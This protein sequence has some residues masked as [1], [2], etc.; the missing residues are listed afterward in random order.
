LRF[1]AAK[2]PP[3]FLLTFKSQNGDLKS[4]FNFWEENLPHRAKPA[5]LN[6]PSH[7]PALPHEHKFS[8]WNQKVTEK[9]KPPVSF[10]SCSVV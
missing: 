5:L 3:A 8:Q 7:L 2:A 10:S 4:I 6:N 9:N 1:S